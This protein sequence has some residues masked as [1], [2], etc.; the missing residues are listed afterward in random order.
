MLWPQ[1]FDYDQEH[2]S[3]EKIERVS[4]SDWAAPIVPVVKKDGSIRICGDYK[5]TVNSAAIVDCYPLPKIEDIFASFSGGKTFTKLDLAHAYNQI[6][7]DDEAKHL[8]TINTSKGSLSIQ[9]I[10]IWC[11]F[12]S[13]HHLPTNNGKYFAGHPKSVSLLG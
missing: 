3:S 13:S 5:R 11:G 9:S 6:E 12:C 1:N 10:T 7:L 4:S 8:A 2:R